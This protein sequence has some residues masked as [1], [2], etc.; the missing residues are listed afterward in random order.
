MKIVKFQWKN[1]VNERPNC[2]WP[3]L[4]AAH[5]TLATK[6]NQWWIIT[7]FN[8]RA[9][10]RKKKIKTL[11]K[12]W[13]CAKKKRSSERQEK[14]IIKKKLVKENES[15]FKAS[16]RLVNNTKESLTK[17]FQLPKLKS[18]VNERKIEKGNWVNFLINKI[19]KIID[20]SAIL[21]LK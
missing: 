8:E 3:N 9:L 11:R 5:K 7:H 1:E 18:W 4:S 19:R 13:S 14:N 20:G 10:W 12:T 6:C 2:S 16:Q 17:L 15:I 21:H